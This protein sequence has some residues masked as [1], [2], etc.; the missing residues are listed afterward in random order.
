MTAPMATY[1]RVYRFLLLRRILSKDTAMIMVLQGSPSPPSPI[2]RYLH[3][4]HRACMM[5]I[6]PWLHCILNTNL[7][8]LFL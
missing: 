6:R 2:C 1:M 8:G 4:R 7:D 3:A 5:A